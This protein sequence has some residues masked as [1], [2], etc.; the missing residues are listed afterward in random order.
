LPGQLI[1]GWKLAV[2]GMGK[3][4][5]RKFILPPDLGYGLSGAGGGVIPPQSTLIFEA[6]CVNV[7]PPPPPPANKTPINSKP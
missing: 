5:W 1:Q 2:D 3:G 6:A 7:A 4:D